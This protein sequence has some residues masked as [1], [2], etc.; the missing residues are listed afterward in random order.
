M[1]QKYK[2]FFLFR[3]KFIRD[4]QKDM[5]D[6]GASPE[7]IFLEAINE[8]PSTKLKRGAEWKLSNIHGI[9]I[10][11]GVFVVGRISQANTE[12]FDFLADEFVESTDYQGPFSTIFFDRT[13]GVVAIEDKSKVNSKVEATAKRLND[14]LNSTD[15]VRR[16][17]VKCIVDAINDPQDFIQ[18]LRKSTHILKFRASFTGPNPIDADV[19]FQKPLE[20]YASA[21]SADKGIIE[22]TGSNLD[23]DVLIDITRSNAATGNTVTAR[24]ETKGIFETIPLKGVRAN[25]NVSASENSEVIFN[26]MLGRYEQVRYETR[27]DK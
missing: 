13:I 10:N 7:N 5:L 19:I 17:K 18:K 14:L 25:F 27:E 9:G 4:H 23:K 24:I 6:D 1:A 2:K 21:T 8:K 22:V 15:A 12:K 16:R 3:V 11:G 20:V 26:Q